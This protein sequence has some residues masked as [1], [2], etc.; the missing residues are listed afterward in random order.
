MCPSRPL[1]KTDNNEGSEMHYLKQPRGAGKSFVF[2]MATPKALV[3]S[4]SPFTGKPFG[5][6]ITLGTGTR[7]LPEARKKRDSYL[8]KVR[9][10]EATMGTD[11]SVSLE[12]AEAWSEA[13]AKQE[14]E[15]SGGPEDLDVRSVLE[16]E[17]EHA[18]SL[19]RSKQPAKRTIERF[20]KVAL[21]TGY[22]IDDA[23][24]RYLEE[25]KIGNR[26]GLKPLSMATVND[27]RTAV[28]YIK[29]F[30]GGDGDICLQDIDRKKAQ[31]FQYEFLSEM[32]TPRAP[33]GL[34]AKTVGKH[35]TLLSGI[36]VWAA[37]R[38]FLPEP[39]RVYRREF[40]SDVRLPYRDFL[41]L[42]RMPP[43]LRLG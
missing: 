12:R 25:R 13:I 37:Q 35:I 21:R 43:L 18:R 30:C 15:G 19:P 31:R 20:T 2:R 16:D 42:H 22:R 33:N 38:G 29:K 7:R 23:V 28:G 17:I 5:S 10:L 39:S 40:C 9:D 1:S 27:V 14:D 8:G 11:A 41:G 4:I 32:V 24:T 36:W 6:E 26:Q 3:G 34:A